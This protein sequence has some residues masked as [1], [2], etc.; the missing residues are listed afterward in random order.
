MCIPNDQLTGHTGN[1][2]VRP[3]TEEGSKWLLRWLKMGLGELAQW[4]RALVAL[5]ED[6]RFNSQHA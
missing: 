1:K 4:L 3:G 2:A 6:L 5:S